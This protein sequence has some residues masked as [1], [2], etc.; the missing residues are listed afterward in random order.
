MKPELLEEYITDMEEIKKI[1][2][3]MYK[4]ILVSKFGHLNGKSL[5]RCYL[6]IKTE[7]KI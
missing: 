4:N 2:S 6:I 5:L 3:A 7:P 1:K